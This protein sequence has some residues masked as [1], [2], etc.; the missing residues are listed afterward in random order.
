MDLQPGQFYQRADLHAHFGGQR[1]GGIVTPKAHPV[2]LLFSSPK[3][4]AYGYRD[5]WLKDRDLYLY[6]GEGTEGD[7]TLDRG[8]RAILEHASQG[9]RLLLFARQ[10]ERG[11]YLYVGEFSYAGHFWS[12]N[13][14]AQGTLRKV[15]TFILKPISAVREGPVAKITPGRT[16]L[17]CDFIRISIETVQLLRRAESLGEITL[18][19]TP[20]NIPP[21]RG[22]NF[23]IK[24]ET[25]TDLVV[26]QLG[27]L[28]LK[29]PRLRVFIHT[30][31]L[32]H[33]T[34]V[35]IEL[36]FTDGR[37]G[38]GMAIQAKVPNEKKLVINAK[39]L[40]ILISH[41][42]KH[43]MLPLYLLYYANRPSF[44][45]FRDPCYSCYL[46]EPYWWTSRYR[47]RQ[48]GH[49]FASAYQV[50]KIIAN[51]A[52]CSV[53]C[54]IDFDQWRQLVW[55]WEYPFCCSHPCHDPLRFLDEVKKAFMRIFPDVGD[56]NSILSELPTY[57]LNLLN[58]EIGRLNELPEE[59][60]PSRH[61]VVVQLTGEE[62]EEK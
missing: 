26:L 48:L 35:D 22:G 24:E 8:N 2:I 44:L 14:D 5:G 27:E 42:Q 53:N 28:A 39:Q 52:N 34:G 19:N 16:Q 54:S 45:F 46:W 10:K 13:T 38:L 33:V 51:L 62:K 36:W 25:L 17:C 15:L 9:K 55:P 58:G 59:I 47:K 7:M 3:G 61:L 4:E 23:K 40:H 12:W 1:Q 18:P 41:A 49:W 29:N 32:E 43:K 37:R 20:P 31:H 60:L 21:R 11:P 30:R 56:L 57:A 50:R 6:S